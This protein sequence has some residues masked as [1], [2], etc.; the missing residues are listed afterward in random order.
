ME[1]KKKSYQVLKTGKNVIGI[2]EILKNLR[3]EAGRLVLMDKQ[4]QRNRKLKHTR[5]K[6]A[7]PEIPRITQAQENECSEQDKGTG[8]L[9]E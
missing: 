6:R 1:K 3:R 4:V 9:S 7:L 2:L 5:E 8:Q